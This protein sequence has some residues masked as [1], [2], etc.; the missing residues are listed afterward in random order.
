M[1]NESEASEFIT[2]L[3][4]PYFGML[5]ALGAKNTELAQE[6]MNLK[7]HLIKRVMDALKETDKDNH[8]RELTEETLRFIWLNDIL[9]E[10]DVLGFPTGQG[11]EDLSLIHI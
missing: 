1:K 3:T 8:T 2:E 4:R 10:L 11:A 9:F 5:V 6:L 7:A